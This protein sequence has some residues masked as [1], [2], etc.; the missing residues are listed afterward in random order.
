MSIEINKSRYK[1][2]ANP[3]HFVIIDFYRQIKLINRQLSTI[4]AHYR[5]KSYRLAFRWSISIDM[6]CPGFT[7]HFQKW[8]DKI[9]TLLTNKSKFHF[10]QYWKQIVP[11]ESTDKGVSSRG[12]RVRT[13]C[14][15]SI[16]DSGSDRVLTM[17]NLTIIYTAPFLFKTLAYL[18]IG[19]IEA[20]TSPPPHSRPY[21]GHLTP[22]PSWDSLD[23]QSLSGCG[24]FDTHT[25]GVGNMNC[26]L[27]FMWNLWHG[28]LSWEMRF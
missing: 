19:Q 15:G 8:T 26:T 7:L 18:C 4:I 6:L 3:E 24:E 5:L 17:Y 22:L 9:K 13:K 12:S 27:D 11:C 20:S 2:I 28:E 14:C 21:R 1:S 16:I 23:S 25:L 10:V